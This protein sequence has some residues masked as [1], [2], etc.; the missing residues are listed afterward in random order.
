MKIPTS[1]QAAL[2]DANWVKATHKEIKA[3][4][5]NG[6]LRLLRGHEA[7]NQLVASGSIQLKKN[8]MTL[9]IVTKQ[10]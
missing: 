4:E 7:I 9:L 6:N 1:L 2:K 8:Q 3:L 10:D 5:R